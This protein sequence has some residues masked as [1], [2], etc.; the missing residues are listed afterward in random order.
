[1][2]VRFRSNEYGPRDVDDFRGRT[3]EDREL[4]AHGCQ[5]LRTVPTPHIQVTDQSKRRSV[6]EESPLDP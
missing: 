3:V 2:Q 6:P 5:S 1:M 4:K